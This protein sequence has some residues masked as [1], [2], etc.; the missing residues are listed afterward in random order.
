MKIKI[1]GIR[2]MQ[3]ADFCD[4]HGVD[5]LG[6]NFFKKSPRYISPEKAKKIITNLEHA[7]PVALFVN[8]EMETI[9]DI[10]TYLEIEITQLHGSES[11]EFL[12]L[13]PGKKIKAFG[14]ENE[15]D[16]EVAEKYSEV[17]DFFLFDKKSKKFGGTGKKFS[18]ELLKNKTIKKDFFL[19]GGISA[20][21]ILDIPEDVKP[22]AID[23]ASSVE[24]EGRKDP[25]KIKEVLSSLRN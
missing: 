5:F 20:D 12:K 11:P 15:Q 6:F 16:L 9:L 7:S 10:I 24:T 14:I 25:E 3:E 23:M 4:Q 18:W 13:I 22:F 17:S 1:C 21:N 2:E 19:A 8:E